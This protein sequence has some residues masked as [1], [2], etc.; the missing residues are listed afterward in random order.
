MIVSPI[1]YTGSK[2]RLIKKGLIKCFPSNINTFYDVFGGSASVSMNVK[3]KK[4]VLTDV[5]KYLV[6][7]WNVF[8][9]YS[10][11]E[12]C[13]HIHGRMD[14]FGLQK[15]LFARYFHNRKKEGDLTKINKYKKCYNNFRHYYNKTKNV[16]DLLTLIYFSFSHQIRFNNKGVFTEPYGVGS[17]VTYEKFVKNGTN[18]FQRDSVTIKRQSFTKLNPKKLKTNDFV[19]FDPPY[20]NSEAEYNKIWNKKKEKKLLILCEELD[21]RG[22]KF[23]L[24]NVSEIKGKV[25]NKLMKWCERNKFYCRSFTLKYGCHVGSSN[26]KEVLITNYDTFPKGTFD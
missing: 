7:L 10:T 24:S 25:N 4:Y 18:F 21:N 9:E 5:D 2:R 22:I 20:F 11:D 12:I 1:P 19:Y 26:S 14:K 8:R 3:A 16:L 23:A 17:F 15:E 6:S 13:K